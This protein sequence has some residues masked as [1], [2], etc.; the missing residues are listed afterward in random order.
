MDDFQKQMLEKQKQFH[1][2][3]KAAFVLNQSLNYWGRLS[4]ID[5]GW[6]RCAFPGSTVNTGNDQGATFT[7]ITP[8][9]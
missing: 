1:E 7:T 3:V 9:F 4:D 6:L 2:R 8:K 5:I